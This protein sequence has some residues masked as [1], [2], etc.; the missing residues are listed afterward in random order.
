MFNVC[1]VLDWF[2]S[3]CDSSF[4]IDHIHFTITALVQ[5]ASLTSMCLIYLTVVVAGSR[6]GPMLNDRN[7]RDSEYKLY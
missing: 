2:D 3:F 5:N 4:G 7:N 1:L 6:Q